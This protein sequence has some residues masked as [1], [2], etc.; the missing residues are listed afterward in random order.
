MV[1][2]FLISIIGD[3]FILEYKTLFFL[4]LVGVCASI[5]QFLVTLAYSIGDASKISIF[6]Y[7]SLI[8]SPILGWIVFRESL[9]KNSYMGIILILSAGYI[10]YL[11]ARIQVSRN[12][13]E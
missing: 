10:S 12:K 9:T 5:A 3:V 11:N 13:I 6:D 4:F 1:F 2:N 7:V 8:V